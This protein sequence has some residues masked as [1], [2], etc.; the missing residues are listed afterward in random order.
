MSSVG[1]NPTP[2]HPAFNPNPEN[3]SHLRDQPAA[4][5]GPA[6]RSSGSTGDLR[7]AGALGG[8]PA[9][10][11]TA[12]SR[13]TSN[14]PTPKRKAET[15]LRHRSAVKCL[16]F[17][18]CPSEQYE[19]GGN[20]NNAT[21][22][23]RRPQPP[24]PQTRERPRDPDHPKSCI[25][26]PCSIPCSA[27]PLGRDTTDE[28]S[29]IRDPCIH[30]PPKIHSRMGAS[31][32]RPP[33][34]DPAPWGAGHAQWGDTPFH[35]RS[36]PAAGSSG[37]HRRASSSLQSHLG[38]AP[39]PAP[40]STMPSFFSFQQGSERAQNVRYLSEASPLLGRFRA[41]PRPSDRAAAARGG[42]GGRGLLVPGQTGL[43]SADPAWRGSVHV[44]YGA[45]AAAAAAEQQEEGD[46]DDQGADSDEDGEEGEAGCLWLGAG[47]R[48]WRRGRGRIRR[49]VRR[50][51]DTW[52]DP[53]ASVIRGVVDVWWS[54][55]AALV[56]LPALLVGL[57]SLF[58]F[59]DPAVGPDRAGWLAE[60][61]NVLFF[62]CAGHR[63]VRDS[64]PAIPPFR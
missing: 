56:L 26:Q 54:R 11:P 58:H 46:G 18:V 60:K 1:L 22:S 3:D 40:T 39:A 38:R 53:K 57:R 51:G 21:T 31:Q 47:G 23:G 32:S 30:Q 16:V 28:R 7:R 45:L 62:V 63:V 42:G 5:G 25:H 29:T 52:V 35:P 43:L 41:V 19:T 59:S 9:P 6:A 34:R 14:Q 24:R 2:Q 50:L 61:A 10:A 37:N 44:G 20:G 13:D 15:I 8:Q 4:G 33:H 36:Q 55:W 64:V 49:L 17:F 27:H 12:A 48:R